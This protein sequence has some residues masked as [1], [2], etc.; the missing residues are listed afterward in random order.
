MATED[1]ENTEIIIHVGWASAHRS[2]L[3]LTTKNKEP[4]RKIVNNK[5]HSEHRAL[6]EIVN[7]K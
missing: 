7:S 3:R 5:G 1:T 2:K 6:R 4:R